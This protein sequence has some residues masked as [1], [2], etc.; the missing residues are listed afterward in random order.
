M[1]Y[2]ESPVCSGLS[3]KDKEDEC[4]VDPLRRIETASVDRS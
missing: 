1:H 2:M 3:N 4:G